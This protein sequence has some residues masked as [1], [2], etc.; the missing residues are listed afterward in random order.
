MTTLMLGCSL[1]LS[2]LSLRDQRIE[3]AIGAHPMM[4]ICAALEILFLAD[5]IFHAHSLATATTFDWLFIVI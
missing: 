3:I 5:P 2:A 1:G 4:N